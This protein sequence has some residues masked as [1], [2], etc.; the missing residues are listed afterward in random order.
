MLYVVSFIQRKV[1]NRDDVLGQFQIIFE[2]N[3][4]LSLTRNFDYINSHWVSVQKFKQL[5]A[6][7]QF[8]KIPRYGLP[9]SAQKPR[10]NGANE[11]A[12]FST[13]FGDW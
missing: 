9:S 8:W 2:D 7:L 3:K 10:T 11:N 4:A 5:Y 1:V 6:I 12:A 13:V